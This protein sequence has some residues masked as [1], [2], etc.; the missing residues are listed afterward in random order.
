[1]DIGIN[2][3]IEAWKSDT[4]YRKI[5]SYLIKSTSVNDY[6]YHQLNRDFVESRTDEGLRRY[7]TEDVVYTLKTHMHES[8]KNEIYYRGDS[9]NRLKKISQIGSFISVTTDIETAY[10]FKDGECCIYKIYVDP[11]VKRISTG[12]EYELILENDLFWNYTGKE[13][14]TENHTMYKVVVSKEPK[15]LVSHMLP[16]KVTSPIKASKKTRNF[17]DLSDDKQKEL[18]DEFN[19]EAT[20]EDPMIEYTPT[21]FMEYITMLDIDISEAYANKIIED[22]KKG[23]GKI[24]KKI[25]Y[26]PMHLFKMRYKSKRK[27]KHNPK[28]KHKSKK[29]FKQ[30]KTNQ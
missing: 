25:K 3:A 6:K 9:D 8:K 29:A 21:G 28:S 14:N 17:E 2:N 1:M 26:L 22:N 19:S 15:P 12:I 4:G 7:K 5:N 24:N 27:S 20:S 16:E 13:E 10:T 18:F 23:G 11:S 30:N